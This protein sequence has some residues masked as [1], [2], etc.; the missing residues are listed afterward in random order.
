MKIERRN[1]MRLRLFIGIC[2]AMFVAGCGGGSS[3]NPVNPVASP[4]IVA[5]TPQSGGPGTPVTIQGSS[6]GAFQGSS[7]ISFAGVTIQPTQWSENVITVT[8][9]N[10]AQNDGAFV[11][12]VGGLYSNPSALFSL[13]KPILTGV[14]PSSGNPGM[15][16]V[17]TGQGFR[18]L[19]GSSYVAFNSQPATVLSWSGTAVTCIVPNPSNFQSGNVSVVVWVDGSRDS[20]PLTFNMT[21]PGITSISPQRDNIGAVVTVFGQGFGLPNQQNSHLTIGGQLATVQS[22]SE[23]AIQAKIPQIGTSGSQN[24]VVMVN[25]HPTTPFTFFV[26]APTVTSFAPSP[27]AQKNQTVSLYGNYF[28]Q[29]QSEGNGQI[30]IRGDAGTDIPLNPTYWSDSTIQFIC[31]IGNYFPGTEHHQVTVIV[32]GI[33]GTYSLTVD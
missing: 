12:T 27:A 14:N 31:P 1:D 19:Q 4:R 2:L 3:S 22:W 10:S 18:S 11:I 16:V 5:V 15:Q 6:F 29:P 24:V 33:S 20:N 7:I 8:I 25:G 28:G 9:P 13:A 23:T 26:E 17:L 32:G 21:T 30:F